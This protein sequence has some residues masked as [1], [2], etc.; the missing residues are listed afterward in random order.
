M[1]IVT[2]T[3]ATSD[4]ADR[5]DLR[6]HLHECARARGRLHRLR[7]AAEAIDAFLAPRFVTALAMVT[8]IVLAGL[9]LST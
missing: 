1:N 9:V 7:C 2:N 3:N 6:H 8:T 5:S 4:R